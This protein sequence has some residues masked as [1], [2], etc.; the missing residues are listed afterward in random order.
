VQRESLEDIESLKN[1]TAASDAVIHL[2]MTHDFSNHLKTC[3]R[4]PSFLET[5][6]LDFG[7]VRGWRIQLY[8]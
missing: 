8:G 5:F 3:E 2:G 7:N 6:K 4:Y 1:G